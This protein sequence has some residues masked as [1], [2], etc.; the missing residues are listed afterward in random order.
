MAELSSEQFTQKHKKS[1]FSWKTKIIFF[2]LLVIVFL[3][4]GGWLYLR[5]VTPKL[6][7]ANQALAE[8]KLLNEERQRCSQILAQQS[9]EFADY[10]Y[11]KQFLQ[12]FPMR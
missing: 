8:L 3:S 6:R 4:V 2:L 12:K 9:G 7:Q 10:D 1:Y 11:C 5:N